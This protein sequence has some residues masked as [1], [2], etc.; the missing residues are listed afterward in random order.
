MRLRVAARR[1]KLPKKKV[2]KV[3]AVAL[4]LGD[5]GVEAVMS[6][7]KFVKTVAKAV[8]KQTETILAQAGLTAHTR[9]GTRRHYAVRGTCV[10]V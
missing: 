10:I 6:G 7:E 4:P 5:N 1:N 3:K 8:A 2:A 9:T